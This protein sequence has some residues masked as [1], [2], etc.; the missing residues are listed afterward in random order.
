MFANVESSAPGQGD[1]SRKGAEIFPKSRY[2]RFAGGAV[3]DLDMG[4]V[5]AADGRVSE[6]RPKTA[7]FLAVLAARAGEVVSKDELM[8][9]VW[10]GLTVDE[11]GLVQ[12]ASEIRRALGEEGRTALRTHT[13]RGYSLHLSAAPPAVARRLAAG[14]RMRRWVPVAVVAA[15]AASLYLGPQVASHNR[16]AGVAPAPAGQAAFDGPTV[17]VLPFEALTAGARWERLARGLTDDV[18]ADMAQNPWLFVL[19]DATTRGLEPQGRLE[20]V[21]AFGG[22]YV[23]GGSVQA[24]NGRA[25]VVA[26]LSDVATGRHVWSKRFEGPVGNVLALQ[27]AAS[28]ALVGELASNWSGPIARDVRVRARGKGT[29]DLAAYELFL[30]AADRAR[31]FAPEDLAASLEML[32][33]VVELAPEFGDAWAKLSLT[34]YNLVSPEMS[35]AEMEAMWEAA[36]EAAMEGYRVSPDA[37]YVLGQAANVVRW[38]NEEQAEQMIRRAAALAPNNADILAYLAFRAAHF[39]ALGAEA[40]GWIERAVRLNPAHPDWYDWN[41]GAVM[42]VVGRYADAAAAYGRSP[43]HPD[44]R[45]GRAAAL[46]LAGDVAAAKAEMARLMDDAPHFTVAWH[47]DAAGLHA[48]VAEIFG[49][50]LALAGA[51]EG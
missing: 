16:Q 10:P 20:A 6:L 8:A 25:H 15:L 3:A 11:D 12:C 33:Q 24:E 39:P 44:A 22:H 30:L 1:P 32:R 43:D 26:T 19:A 46:A 4:Q 29:D 51:P 31:S 38:E 42:M 41:R 27:R 47:R 37:P 17:A 36:A 18:I 2:V 7:R 23:V 34:T 48:E 13:G 28:E 21:R 9:E 40:E 5:R 49:R 35:P 14:G 50:G 45:A